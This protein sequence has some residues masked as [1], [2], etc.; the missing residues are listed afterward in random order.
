MSTH[1]IYSG[2]VLF[3]IGLNSGNLLQLK[4]TSNGTKDVQ[5]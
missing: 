4:E 3:S 2:V 5:E 1:N